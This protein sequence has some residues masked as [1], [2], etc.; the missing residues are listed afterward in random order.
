MVVSRNSRT[1][2]FF[3]REGEV[4]VA[5]ERAG[6]NLTSGLD[7]PRKLFQESSLRLVT[8]GAK[9]RARNRRRRAVFP[10]RPSRLTVA[11]P[12]PKSGVVRR[13]VGVAEA[14]AS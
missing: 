8:Q 3:S 12:S 13:G 5:V 1:Y 6:E 11:P 9:N 7:D 2:S 4:V 14:D 10:A